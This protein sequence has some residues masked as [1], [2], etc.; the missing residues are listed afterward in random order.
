MNAF[1]RPRSLLK[2]CLALLLCLGNAIAQS[3][4]E[5]A[6]AGK[7][8]IAQEKSASAD[9]DLK[10]VV[11]LFRH[12]VRAPLKKFAEEEAP[13]HAAQEWPRQSDWHAKDWGDLTD[14]GAT[15]ANSLG[16]FY[17]L[18]YKGLFNGTFKVF[19]WADVDPRTKDTAKF[20]KEG[21]E[22][23]GNREITIRFN[24]SKPDPLYHAFAAR[25]GEPSA[26]TLLAISA[27]VSV[28]A[29]SYIEQRKDEF[30]QLEKVL[31]CPPAGAPCTPLPAV[32]DN[33]AGYCA[34]PTDSC[35]SPLKWA[36][37]FPYA[38]SVT[39]AFLLEYANHMADDQV[40]WKRVRPPNDEASSKIQDML[41]LHEFYFD[42]TQ[43]QQYLARIDAS[44]LVREINAILHRQTG[45]CQH[46]P[47][48]SQFVGLIGHDTNLASLGKLLDL[49]WDFSDP[50]LPDDTRGL[51]ANDALPAGALVFELRKR[52]PE[53]RD[54]GYF[55]RV[56]YVTQSLRQMRNDP[57]NTTAFALNVKGLACQGSP[58]DIPLTG[59]N[60][61]A[62]KALDD[63]RFLSKCVNG[64]QV[65]E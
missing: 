37:Q 48:E 57:S 21:F 65:C 30:D 62:K 11:A 47:L 60:Q 63:G 32:T 33:S 28:N 40:G 12:G 15:L 59:F 3:G 6:S 17:A 51:P 54:D 31:A 18:R 36:G 49:T 25:C 39:E 24:D 44:N 27:N 41:A 20:L 26:K 13:K 35:S 53:P 34:R 38:S 45:G 58:C 50:R 14:Q 29:K 56:Y 9:G 8:V 42:Q 64:K 52:S 43:R 7:P 19:L 23:Q 55:V 5:S 2:G 1:S 22:A 46:A 16:Q 4:S 10:L 61:L